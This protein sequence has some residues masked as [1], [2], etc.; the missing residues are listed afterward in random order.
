MP[1]QLTAV[2][3]AALDW[4]PGQQVGLSEYG[5]PSKDGYERSV[6]PSGSAGRHCRRGH[7]LRVRSLP[8]RRKC[9][10]ITPSTFRAS[11]LAQPALPHGRDGI[12]HRLDRHLER[13]DLPGQR[14]DLGPA[15]LVRHQRDE[16]LQ[17]R[18]DL[19]HHPRHHLPTPRQH[20]LPS[21]SSSWTRRPV[22]TFAAQPDLAI[23]TTC[24]SETP[25]T[26]SS[27]SNSSHRSSTPSW[28]DRPGHAPSWSGSTTST[29]A[30]TTTGPARRRGRRRHRPCHRAGRPAGWLHRVRPPGAC[31]RRQPLRPPARRHQRRPQPHLGP[32]HHRAAVEPAGVDLPATPGQPRWRTSWSRRSCPSPIRRTWPPPPTPSP[33]FCRDTRANPFRRRPRPRRPRRAEPEGPDRP[34]LRRAP[35]VCDTSVRGARAPQPTRGE[36]TCGLRT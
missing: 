15:Q 34:A 6:L 21:P 19:G 32:G 11:P 4:S 13:H 29:A 14:D 1:Q 3:P 12:G 5:W 18:A 23:E 27:A 20:H 16:L 26:S 2:V 10:A 35:K 22:P 9:V 25:R 33:A 31:R 7:G 30:T 24:Q 8:Q 17:R 36:D 28:R